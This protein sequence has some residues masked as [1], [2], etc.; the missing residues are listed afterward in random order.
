MFVFLIIMNEEAAGS[1][2]IPLEDGERDR[3]SDSN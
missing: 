1:C 2:Y 3:P